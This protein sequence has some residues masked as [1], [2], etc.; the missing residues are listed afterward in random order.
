MHDIIYYIPYSINYDDFDILHN[1][2][3]IALGGASIAQIEADGIF[4]RRGSHLNGWSKADKKNHLNTK[5]CVLYGQRIV[6]V[7]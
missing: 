4:K 6:Y 3:N 5:N 1:N 2:T 7:F